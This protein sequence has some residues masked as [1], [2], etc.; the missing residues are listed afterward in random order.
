MRKT[1]TVEMYVGLTDKTWHTEMVDVPR[2][3]RSVNAIKKEA[4]R[5]LLKRLTAEGMTGLGLDCTE[6]A[7]VGLYHIQPVEEE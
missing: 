1:Q 7:F 3:L 6:V 5:L 2:T 4:T